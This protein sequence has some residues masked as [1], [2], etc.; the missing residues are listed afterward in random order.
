MA[1]G[2]TIFSSLT[3]IKKFTPTQA[4][5]FPGGKTVLSYSSS[6]S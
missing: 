6:K 1:T 4:R 3:G 5:L 2:M